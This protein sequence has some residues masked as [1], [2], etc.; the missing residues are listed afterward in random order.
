MTNT[1]NAVSM[2]TAEA[3]DAAFSGTTVNWS[4]PTGAAFVS[5][6]TSGQGPPRPPTSPSSS[7]G[8]PARHWMSGA[9]RAGWPGRCGTGGWTSWAWTSR[10]RR[11]DRP[12]L[13]ALWP[14]AV[15]S[16]RRY[17]G[18]GSGRMCCSPTATSDWAGARTVCYAGSPRSWVRAALCWSSLP[19]QGRCRSTKVSACGSANVTVPAS[20]GLPSGW[21][22]SPTWPTGPDWS[23]STGSTSTAG[24]LRPCS[25]R[26][27]V[28]KP[29]HR[30]QEAPDRDLS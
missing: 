9:D 8:A 3:L 12:G 4:V 16:S 28:A 27:D 29:H 26:R 19:G 17:R 20:I 13:V 1:M 14:C 22:P 25:T 2:T 15:T 11:S 18:R 24:M 6:P 10:P 21:T 5:G 7:T 30:H 23:W